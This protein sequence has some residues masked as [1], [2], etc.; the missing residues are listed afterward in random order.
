LF[1]FTGLFSIFDE[2]FKILI[3][4]RIVDYAVLDCAEPILSLQGVLLFALTVL[5]KEVINS[6]LER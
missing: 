3:I 2:I 5:R 1:L 4:L 6:F